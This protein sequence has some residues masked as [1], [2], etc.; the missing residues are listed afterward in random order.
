MKA[1]VFLAP[2]K[3][4]NASA[5]AV[6]QKM[7]QDRSSSKLKSEIKEGWGMDI[8]DEDAQ[9]ILSQAEKYKKDKLEE[10]Y[11]VG[12]VLSEKYTYTG[13]ATHGHSGG[14]VPLHAFGPGRPVG[15]VDGPEIGT[16]CAR[17]MGLE[18]EKLNQRLFADAGKAFGEGNVTID[19]KDPHNPVAMIQYKGKTAELPVDQNWLFLDGKATRLEGLVVYSAKT[20]KLYI[21]VQAV[22]RIKGVSQAPPSIT[23]GQGK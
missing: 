12:K 1:D 20:N 10:Y 14:D 9:I 19:K 8:T 18:L 16:L 6:W 15:V 13:W 23:V 4:M 5:F 7:G 17:V 22:N 2:F 11:A 21:P 3:K